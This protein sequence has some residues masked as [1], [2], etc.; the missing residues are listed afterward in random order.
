MITP[1]FRK[2]NL[3]AYKPGRS[4]S[5]NNK[6]VI[7]LS[8]NESALGIGKKVQKILKTFDKKFQNIQIAS[9]KV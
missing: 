6:K 1:T 2:I 5:K 8:A 9:S 7:K 3:D 4:I